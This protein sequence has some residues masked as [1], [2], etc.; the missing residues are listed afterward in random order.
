[1]PHPLL[2]Q[3]NTRCWLRAWSGLLGRP[4]TLDTVPASEIA[5]WKQR[6]VTHVWLMGVWTVGP[7]TRDL[8]RAQP[9]LRALS[10]EAFGTEDGEKLAGSP[11]AVEDFTV[12]ESL[13]GSAALRQFRAQLHCY[14]LGLVL[15]FIPNH[16][17]LD[18]RWLTEKHSLFMRS[19]ESRPETFAVV[20]SGG[21]SW[22]AHGKDPFLAAW[23]DTA[24]LDYRQSATREAMIEILQSIAAQCDGARCDTAMLLLND[25]F[26]KTWKHFPADAPAPAEEFWAEAIAAVKQRHPRFVFI[27]EAYWDLEPQLQA[28]GFD[29]AYDK[30][31]IEH[32]TRRDFPAL[33][34]H[35][36]AV[37]GQ[38]NP[39]RFLE[40][41]DEARI[42]SL[43]SVPEQK[44]AAVL[45]L[46]QPGLRLLHDGQLA[47][48]T[49]RTPVQFADYWPEHANAEMTEFYDHLLGFV[50]RTTVG[51]GEMEFCETGLAHC[52][53]M[54]WKKDESGFDLAAVNL[55]G[56]GAEFHIREVEPGGEVANIYSDNRSSW[57]C[58]SNGL[59]IRLGAYG[60][61]L[62][63]GRSAPQPK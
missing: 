55:A 24:Q 41:H 42:A 60:F 3:V 5:L 10:K 21:T 6:G 34:K 29:Y 36:R 37:G 40:N 19:E 26:D 58:S 50:A 61:A 48:K 51:H 27:A 59:Q 15:D 18:H 13:G 12:A 39:V 62:L 30:R 7:K 22:V 23:N 46:A 11:F 31:F 2:F 20:R 53:A 49:R 54:K 28:L 52:F 63:Q 43:L 38:F 17:G 33:Q 44:A 56:Q 8:A 45:L 57:S 35:V 1:M 14:G 25:V 9:E 32:L 47:G 16:L 4:V